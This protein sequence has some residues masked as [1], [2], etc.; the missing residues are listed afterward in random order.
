MENNTT[1]DVMLCNELIL[2]VIDRQVIVSKTVWVCGTGRWNN[3]KENKVGILA[4]K[5]IML[6][7]TMQ[8][9]LI[10]YYW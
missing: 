1:I 9:L 4:I 10:N 2:M 5:R 3:I 7:L 6:L 8:L